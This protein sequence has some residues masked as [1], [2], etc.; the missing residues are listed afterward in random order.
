MP[1]K[2]EQKPTAAGHKVQVTGL[3]CAIPTRN[4]LDVPAVVFATV[5]FHGSG[6]EIEFETTSPSSPMLQTPM[7]PE[8]AEREEPEAVANALLFTMYSPFL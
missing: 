2:H 6:P 1:F 4:V 3:F 8:E 5:S 7:T